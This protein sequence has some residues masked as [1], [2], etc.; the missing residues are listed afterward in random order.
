MTRKLLLTLLVAA[1]AVP[2]GPVGAGA[3]E[4]VMLTWEDA[5]GI[6]LERSYTV[7]SY[8][9]SLL[10][11]QHS[12]DYYKAMFKPRIDFSMFAPT[13]DESVAPIQQPN[14]LPVYNSVGQL[15]YGSNLKFT[16]MLP[17]GGNLALSSRL[18][19]ENIKTVLALQNYRTLT[20]DQAFSSLSLSFEQPIFTDNTL[21]E[22]LDEAQYRYERM[23]SQ[24]TR[25]QMN[26]IYDVTEGFY[27]LYRATRGVDIAREKLKHSEEAYRIATL[28]Y[29]S[30]RIAEGD[31]LIAEIAMSQNRASLLEYEGALQREMDRFRQLI[32][33]GSDIE[34]GIVTNLAYDIFEI[35]PDK[36]MEEA[37]KNR[38]EIGEAD[39]QIRLQEIEVD[40][41]GRVREFKGSVSAYYD[42]TGVSTLG[43]G[44]TGELFDSSFDN[45]IERPPNRGISLTFS[46]P[47]FDWGRGKSRVQQETVDLRKAELDRENLIR[48]IENG[49]RD[50]TRRVTESLN[51]LQIHEKNQDVA[52]RSLDISTLRFENGDITSQDLAQVQERLA[53]TQLQYL[54]AFIAY[55][56]ALNDLKRKTLW[57]FKNNRS[58]VIEN[59]FKERVQ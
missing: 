33:I 24:F 18:Y 23:S 36:A 12:F 16:Y 27:R 35:D 30:G 5:I 51:R 44:T 34:I 11:M 15:R 29:E 13:L 53:E 58:Y 14:G 7:K 39:L 8:Q 4:T 21:K 20:N 6:A 54:D 41:A 48:D 9:A 2:A 17:T 59:E 28:K 57:D 19:R 46:Y 56:L 47:V 10:S 26:I 25:A 45:F 40:R 49:V 22:N 50:T 32:G 3:G 52:R 1:V 38:L 31:V 43:T 42:L 37:L 55:Q